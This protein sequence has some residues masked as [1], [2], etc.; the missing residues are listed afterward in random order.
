M[1]TAKKTTE[2]FEPAP[3]DFAKFA[4]SFR[5]LTEKNMAQGTEAYDKFKVAAE[6]AT[7]TAQKAFDALREGT[8]AMSNKA[9]ENARTNTEASLA[10]FEKLAG[11]KTVSELIELQGEFFRTS[12][13]NL[14]AQARETQELSVR[15]S[16]E[17]ATPVKEAAGKAVEAATSNTA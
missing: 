15:I 11:A 10:F 2:A 17:S 16:E 7:E 14:A 8:A 13:E 5:H 4:D 6:E 1:A 9:F 3:F 12:F